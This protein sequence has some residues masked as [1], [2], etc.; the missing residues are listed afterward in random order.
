M[1]FAVVFIVAL[2]AVA[3][4]SKSGVT[5]FL[6]FPLNFSPKRS[7]MN[8]LAQVEAKLKM[9]GPLDQITTMLDDFKK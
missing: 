3:Q 9:N 7:M 1:K 5:M 8:L 4:A 6:G 2:I